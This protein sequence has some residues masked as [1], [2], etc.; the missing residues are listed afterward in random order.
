[1]FPWRSIYPWV[2]LEISA[3]LRPW[4]ILKALPMLP[5]T[6]IIKKYYFQTG[7]VTADFI[8]LRFLLFM[9]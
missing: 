4:F 3:T 8:S 6:G 9:S 5:A 2:R 7:I 1:M